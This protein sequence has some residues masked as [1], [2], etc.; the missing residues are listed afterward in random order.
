MRPNGTADRRGFLTAV[1]ALG[2]TALSGCLDILDRDGPPETEGDDD[3]PFEVDPASLLLTID[4]VDE[5]L[6]G[7][8]E[9]GG[10]VDDPTLLT[11]GADAVTSFP[12]IGGDVEGDPKFVRSAVWLYGST[13]EAHDAYWDHPYRFGA[14]TDEM[15]IASESVV[16]LTD[17]PDEDDDIGYRYNVSYLLFRDANALGV[18]TYRDT[19]RYDGDLFSVAM[20][21]AY[22]KHVTWR[23]ED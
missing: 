18:V 6:P 22:E 3:D 5:V 12:F 19:D 21:L 14:W 9:E 4:T 16:G 15:E 1:V 11:E 13:E 7:D 2:G 10:A 23:T 20:D 8:W 17:E